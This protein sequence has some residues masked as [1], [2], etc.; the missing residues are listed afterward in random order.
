[1]S[2]E[3]SAWA[4]EQPVPAVAKL[5]LLLAADVTPFDGSSLPTI[6]ELYDRTGMLLGDFE[7]YFNWL[8][9]KGFLMRDDDGVHVQIEPV[10]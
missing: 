4:S 1:M 8:E 3:H 9:S 10:I 6:A 5:I 7:A 2:I